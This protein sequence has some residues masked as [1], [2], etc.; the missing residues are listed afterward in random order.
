MQFF[1]EFEF[2]GGLGQ[3]SGFDFKNSGLV[4][5]RLLLTNSFDLM[6]RE[7]KSAGFIVPGQ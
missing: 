3:N 5:Q 6:P 7:G 4:H 1:G 2:E